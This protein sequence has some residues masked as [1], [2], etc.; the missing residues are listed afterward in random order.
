MGQSVIAATIGMILGN[1]GVILFVIGGGVAYVRVQRARAHH[2]PTAVADRYWRELLFYAVGLS[3]LWYGVLHAFFQGV[4]TTYIGWQ[5]SP[6]EFELGFAEIGI[7]VVALLART[8]SYDLGFGVTLIFAIFSLAAAAQHISLI[9]CCNNTKP[10]NAGVILWFNDIVL[11]LLL[12]WL[13]WRARSEPLAGNRFRAPDGKD[14]DPT[15]LP[16]AQIKMP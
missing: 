16:R 9:V 8:R 13:A 11:P 2:R 12:L 3:F 5:P 15:G 6:F 10:G 1:L 7:G 14:Q 4:S